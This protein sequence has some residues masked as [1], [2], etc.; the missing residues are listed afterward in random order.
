MITADE[1]QDLIDYIESRMCEEARRGEPCI[2][3]QGKKNLIGDR[4]P[5]CLEAQR[6]IEIAGKAE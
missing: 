5:A 3:R 2:D 6:M 1:R 4:H